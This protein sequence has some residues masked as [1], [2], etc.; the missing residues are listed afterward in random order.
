MNVS[1]NAVMRAALAEDVPLDGIGVTGLPVAD[2]R[3]T[4]AM[5]MSDVERMPARCVYSWLESI[6]IQPPTLESVD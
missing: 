6:E 2:P 4:P 5:M 3:R 1:G